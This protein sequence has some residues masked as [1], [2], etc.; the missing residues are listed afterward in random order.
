MRLVPYLLHI[1]FFC[2][3]IQTGTAQCPITVDAGDD[4]FV[5]QAGDQATLNGSIIGNFLGFNWSPA[6]GLDDPMSLTPNA[7]VTGPMIYTLTG[8]AEDPTAPNL[9]TN[10]AFEDGNMGFFSNFAFNPLPVTPGTYVLT[11]SPSVVLSSFPPCDDH[12]FGNGTGNMML[13]NGTGGVADVW[14]QT[15]TVNPNSYYVM[16]A[17]V[18][19]A[20]LSPPTLQFSVNGVLVGSSYNASGAGC[21]WEQF[22][23]GWFS[24]P[25]A[26]ITL[27]ITDQSTSGN[28]FL[29]DFFALDDVYFAEACSESDEVM[30]DVVEVEAVLPV[31]TVLECNALPAGMMLDGTGSTSGPDIT[32]QWTTGSG[33]IVSGANTATPTI[34]EIGVYTLTVTFDNGSAFCTDQASIEVLSDPNFVIANA[35]A[36]DEINCNNLTVTID[37]GGSSSGPTISYDWT[38]LTG[39]VSGET[40]QYPEVIT[41]GIYTLTVT[42]SISG[43]TESIDVEVF[44]N[45]EEPD[46]AA[47]VPGPIDCTDLNQTLSGAGSSTGPEYS[48]LWTTASGN[49]VSGETTLNNCVVESGGVYQLT[50]T[51][52]LNSCIAFATVTVDENINLPTAIAQADSSINCTQTTVVVSGNGS[53]SGSNISYAWNTD[54]GSIVSGNNMINATVD[55]GGVY[56]FQVTDDDSGCMATDTVIVLENTTVPT[57]VTAAPFEI[58]CLTDSVQINGIGSSTGDSIIYVWTSD[59]GNILSGDS[60]LSPFVDVA[61]EY[62]LTVTDTTNGCAVM[63]TVTA[64][65]NLATPVSEAGLPVAIGCDGNPETLDGAGSSTGTEFSYL[66]TTNGGNVLSGANSLTPEIN[67]PGWYF[68]TTTNSQN[69]CAAIDSVEVTG[70][71]NAPFA[72]ATVNDSL[73][74]NVSQLTIDGSNSDSGPN[75]SVLW[76]TTEG[77]IISGETSLMPVVDAGGTYVLTLTNQTNGCATSTSVL[78]VQ[79]TLAPEVNIALPNLLNCFTPFDTLDAT[80]SSQGP[81]FSQ[82]WTTV[83]GNIVAGESTL[84]PIIDSGGAYILTISNNITGCETTNSVAVSTDFDPPLADAGNDQTI[85]C[86]DPLATLSGVNSSQGPAFSYEWTTVQGNI[87]SGETTLNPVVDAQGAYLLEVT[88]NLNGCTAVS[89]VAVDVQADFPQVEAGLGGNLNCLTDELTLNATATSN[90]DITYLW[91][92]PNGNIVS[93]ETTLMPLVDAPGLYFLTVTNNLNGCEAMDSAIVQQST[94]PPNAD[95]GAPFTFTCGTSSAFLDGTGS[96]I[97]FEIFYQWTTPNGNIIAG[98]TT[99][100]PE[101]NAP[102]TYILEVENG[103]TGCVGLDTVTISQDNNGPVADAGPPGTLNCLSTI[104]QLDG[105]ASDSGPDIIYFW[106]TSDGNII[107]GETTTTPMVDAPGTYILTVINTSNN[108]QTIATVLI[109]DESTGPGIDLADVPEVNCIDSVFTLSTLTDANNPSFSWTTTDGIIISGQTTAMPTIQGTGTYQVNVLDQITGCLSDTSITVTEDIVLPDINLAFPLPLTCLL[110]EIILNGNGSSTGPDISYQWTTTDG[111]I[112]GAD[113]QITAIAILDGDYTFTVLDESNGCSVSADLT[114]VDEAILPNAVAFVPVHLGCGNTAINIDGSG[115]SVG[116]EFTYLWTTP[117]G[118]IVSGATTLSPVV[119]EPG[120][121]VI[122]VT[123][124]EN[125]CTQAAAVEVTEDGNNPAIFIA[126]ST[127]LTCVQEA[128]TIDANGSSSGLGFTLEWTTID[129]NIVDGEMTLT[130]TVNEPGTYILTIND[131]LNGC[132]SVDSITVFENTT[133]PL[134]TAGSDLTLNC[135]GSPLQIQGSLS[136]PLNTTFSWTYI[137]DTG[138]TG[139]PFISGQQT[140]NPLVNLPGTYTLTTT[141]TD[142]GCTSADQTVVNP[143]DSIGFLFETTE[144][145]CF[146]PFGSIIFTEVQG[147]QSP[148]IYSIDGQNFSEDTVFENLPAANYMPTVT[149]VDGCSATATVVFQNPLPFTINLDASASVAQGE[150]VSLLAQVTLPAEDIDTIVWTPSIGLSCSDCLTPTATP[151]ELTIYTIVVTDINGCTEQA[152]INVSVTAPEF[153]IFVP[154]AFSPNDDGI[155]DKLVVYANDKSVQQVN[156]FLIFDRWGGVVFEAYGFPVNNEDHGWDGKKQDELLNVGVFAW[157]AEVLLVNGGKEIVEGEV[158]LIR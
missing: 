26:S 45:T 83:G 143:S 100:M 148:Y 34:N 32:Y 126:P 111:L 150:S 104:L 8:F 49:I 25:N 116:N 48:Y 115:S 53:S 2:A 84:Q 55:S 19:S 30:V 29:G 69:G 11:T 133:P 3:F 128:L 158:I 122:R 41:G 108:C 121:Y 37:G 113:D 117:D 10:P 27:C 95:A 56:V 92:T 131:T 138:V 23:A 146:D 57:A 88:N 77:N 151:D 102:G 44:E 16:S 72:E 68:I 118:N 38:P 140:L 124:N 76:E 94:N 129:G 5:C 81:E 64:I 79:D 1:L 21:S 144:P 147:G 130:P 28:G 35:F 31:T 114:V 74:C 20:P 97:G 80:A 14:C 149:D 112:L 18:A 66:W 87:V 62:Y 120:T 142:N 145:D 4:P 9:V 22:S 123:N 13:V 71:G 90:P 135:D 15:I 119:D 93:G 103:N 42:N 156:Q 40:T 106:S 70:D 98:A 127:E 33:N 54:D 60:T 153:N 86:A 91:T 36:P 39:I 43:C 50:V 12:T 89:G 82:I 141:N 17:W 67:A 59:T 65:S 63:D 46:A 51:N 7:T 109:D 99:P 73:D 110:E 134:V 136:T 139:D 154:N 157:F 85:D 152:S 24:G 125:G 78:V 52:D 47:S 6:A 137:P 105:T 132:S 75:I 101:I 155:N 96:D 107:S 58:T 61:G